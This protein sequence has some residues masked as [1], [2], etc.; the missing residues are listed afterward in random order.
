[1]CYSLMDLSIMQIWDTDLSYTSNYQFKPPLLHHLVPVSIFRYVL[2]VHP[3]SFHKQPNWCDCSCCILLTERQQRE[4]LM[5]LAIHKSL[6]PAAGLFCSSQHKTQLKN[7][8]EHGYINGVHFKFSNLWSFNGYLTNVRLFVF[9]W[10]LFCLS[11]AHI[12]CVNLTDRCEGCRHAVLG[13]EWFH[14]FHN[15]RERWQMWWG[16]ILYICSGVL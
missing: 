16:N 11:A 14:C 7:E 4:W 13:T 6:L 15:F 10:F 9:L 8:F 12:S 3:I 5:L 2:K 1:M